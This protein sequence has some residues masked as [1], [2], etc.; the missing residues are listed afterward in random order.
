MAEVGDVCYMLGSA[1]G[2]TSMILA[3]YRIMAAILARYA[4]E[5]GWHCRLLQKGTVSRVGWS[6]TSGLI[7]FWFPFR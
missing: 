6:L 7:G 3:L 2:A 4:A 1:C 5:S